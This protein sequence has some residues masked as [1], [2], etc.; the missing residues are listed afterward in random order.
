MEEGGRAGDARVAVVPANAGTT[1][2]CCYR[3]TRFNSAVST[4]SASASITPPHTVSRSGNHDAFFR[5]IETLQR[6]MQQERAAVIFGAVAGLR[7]QDKIRLQA[8]DRFQRSKSA[9]GDAEF[10]GRIEQA[11][12]GQERTDQTVA[13]GD[14]AAARQRQHAIMLVGCGLTRAGD[15]GIE[16]GDFGART[17]RMSA[18]PHPSR[19]SGPSPRR[20]CAA[21]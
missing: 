2:E 17:I 9:K 3:L 19:G 8:D 20:A 16:P 15:R 10:A 5:R 13:A 4:S 7:H 14:P 18:R 1:E 21:P 6:R 11:G 12:F